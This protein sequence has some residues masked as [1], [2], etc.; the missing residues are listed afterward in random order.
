MRGRDGDHCKS[1]ASAIREERYGQPM[2]IG[3]LVG[4]FASDSTKADVALVFYAGHGAQVNG[5]NYLLPIDIDIPRTE[6]DIQFAGL[7]V[8]DLVN[9]IGSNTKIVFLDACRDNPVLFKNLVKGR[10]SSPTGLAP[11]SS[12]NFDQR[13]GGGVFIA[14][15]TDAGA[16]ADDGNGKHSPFTQ[17]LLRNIQKPISIDDMFSL[18]TKEVRLVTKNAQRPYKRF[19]REHHLCGSE[20]FKLDDFNQC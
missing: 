1:I 6:V 15:A 4:Q 7:K 17:A 3:E 14:Y 10:G 11:A 8:D 13:S 19:S 12:A 16:V 9:S 18:V 20:L 2:R 5:N